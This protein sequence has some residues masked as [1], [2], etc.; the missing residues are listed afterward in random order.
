MELL[1]GETLRARLHAGPL[2]A[3]KALDVAEQVARGLAAAHEKGVVHRDLK[4]E[5]VF[6]TKDGL[7]KILDFGLAKAT[8]PAG[9]RGDDAR[10]DRDEPLAGGRGAR[11]R[12]YMSPEQ[13]RG[14]AADHRSIS[15]PFGV[16]LFEMLMGVRPFQ[17]KSPVETLMAILRDDPPETSA[18]D[19]RSRPGARSSGTVWRSLPRSGSESA[20]DLAYALRVAERDGARLVRAARGFRRPSR[21]A[22]RSFPGVIA[23]LRSEICSADRDAEL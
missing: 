15:S 20:R 14:E 2:P 16:I 4:P 1:E 10:R 5:N 22:A 21:G 6:L 9:L 3:R 11:D 18:R 23:V 7:V 19:S 17:R 13:V 12:G 8:R